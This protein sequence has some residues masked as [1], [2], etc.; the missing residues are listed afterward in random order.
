MGK[1]ATLHKHEN[2]GKDTF[3]KIANTLF[4]RNLN[5]H[6]HFCSYWST[7]F[8]TQQWFSHLNVWE[9]VRNSTDEPHDCESHMGK[10]RFLLSSTS[11]YLLQCLFTTHLCNLRVQPSTQMVSCY[12][13]AAGISIHLHQG[14]HFWSMAKQGPAQSTISK[15]MHI[16]WE[17]PID[18]SK[19][20]QSFAGDQNTWSSSLH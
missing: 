8:Y 20:Q 9:G 14:C 12:I 19:R 16:E 6:Q 1:L 5:C 18:V 7:L 17:M 4:N 13:S 11:L 15:K 10:C 2:R 3:R